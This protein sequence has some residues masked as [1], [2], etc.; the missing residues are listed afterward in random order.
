MNIQLGIYEIF[1]TIIPGCVFLVALLQL[2]IMTKV[3]QIDWDSLNNLTFVSAIFILVVAYL[4][5]VTFGRFGLIW[6]KVFRRKNQ[7][8]ESLRIFKLRHESRWNIDFTDD[9]WHVLL[10]FIRSKNLDLARENERHLASS[11]MLRNVSFGFLLLAIINLIHYFLVLN[12]ALLIVGVV[13]FAL[14]ILAISESI[15]F[16]RWY[17]DSILSSVLAYR[18]ELEK[19]IK[20][21]KHRKEQI[22]GKSKGD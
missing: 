17:Y 14:S 21:V 15:K 12:L 16:R 4:L 3:V 5:G 7:S 1:S 6:Y 13:M 18:V 10:A 9:D 22:K 11:I 19:S 8:V 20:S 2:L